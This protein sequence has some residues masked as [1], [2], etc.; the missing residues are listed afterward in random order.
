MSNK[1]KHR[2]KHSNDNKLFSSKWI[3]PLKEAVSD[4]SYLLSRSYSE[5]SA[6]KIVGDRYKLNVRQRKALL[7]ASCSD[8]S[9][10]YRKEHEVTAKAIKG[11]K[12]SI[13]GYNILITL[14]SAFGG[15][16]IFVCRDGC[17][18]DI[19]SI[20][21]TYRKVEETSIA[22]EL[23]GKQLV[24]LG[25]AEVKWL[26]D[27][28]V[29]NSGRLRGFMYEL[30]EKSQFTWNIELVNNPDK[31]LAKQQDAIIVS[32]DGWILDRSQR[33]CNLNKYLIQNFVASPSLINLQSN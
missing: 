23:I 9:R 16:I 20:H 25:A 28:P 27:A 26:F 8:S 5:K 15:G 10:T 14:E 11:Q 24:A 6:L 33:W 32:A 29:S 22:L 13:D 4:L 1:Q 17:Y 7:R 18:R 2:G 31:E 19:A 3:S 30:A 21:S 12:V